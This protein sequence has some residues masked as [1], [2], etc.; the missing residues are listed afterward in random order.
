MD[1]SAIKAMA[2]ILHQ[3]K[4]INNFGIIEINGRSAYNAIPETSVCNF[5]IDPHY[6][7]NLQEI[8]NLTLESIRNRYNEKTTKHDDIVVNNIII[9]LLLLLHQGPLSF[10]PYSYNCLSI[11]NNIG[12]ITTTI[13]KSVVCLGYHMLIV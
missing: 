6:K 3:F 9:D 10:S 5:Y 7:N 12:L 13:L 8:I 2:H 11:S 4:S 1:N